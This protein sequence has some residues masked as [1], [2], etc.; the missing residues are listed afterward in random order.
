M[1]I[2]LDCGSNSFGCNYTSWHHLRCDV[3]EAT[4]KYLQHLIHQEKSTNSELNE[5]KL[6]DYDHERNKHDIKNFLN[7]M[8]QTSKMYSSRFENQPNVF[9]INRFTHKIFLSI[10]QSNITYLD[11]FIRTDIGGLYSFCYKSDCEGFYSSGNSMDICKLFDKIKPFI[12]E[13][14]EDT[15]NSIY[16][17]NDYHGDEYQGLYKL[18]ENSWKNDM[19]VRIN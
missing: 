2:D 7:K 18:F 15:Y 13:M 9:G 16:S 4:L 17:N 3:I 19:I 1:G 8:E 5:D 10:I 11:L 14:Y 6:D 12:K